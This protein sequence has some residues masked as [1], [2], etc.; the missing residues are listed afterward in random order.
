LEK[1]GIPAIETVNGIHVK[2]SSASADSL[3]GSDL[4]AKAL[5]AYD[6][7]GQNVSEQERQVMFCFGPYIH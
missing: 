7:L 1:K 4:P 5:A 3:D 6:V 2:L